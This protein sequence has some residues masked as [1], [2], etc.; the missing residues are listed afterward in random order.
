MRVFPGTI[1]S[2]QAEKY[3]SPNAEGHVQNRVGH[4]EQSPIEWFKTE[5]TATAQ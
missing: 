3:H 2:S 5:A 1:S 4:L